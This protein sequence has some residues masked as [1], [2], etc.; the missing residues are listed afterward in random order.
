M[1]GGLFHKYYRDSFRKT[2]CWRGTG[3]YDPSDPKLVAQIRNCL[4]W[5]GINP[6]RPI[7]DQR[8]T[9]NKRAY[10]LYS[11]RSGLDG[12]DRTS[13]KLKRDRI[14]ATRSM[15]NGCRS[16]LTSPTPHCPQAA[17]LYK[18]TT[19]DITGHSQSMILSPCFNPKGDTRKR[20]AS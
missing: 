14:L 11:V 12:Q 16:P 8:L 5:T 7:R 6:G 15:I 9:F 20:D 18:A 19:E 4:N 17:T 13:E 1:D 2:P 3:H 10:L